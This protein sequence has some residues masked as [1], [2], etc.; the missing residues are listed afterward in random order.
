MPAITIHVPESRFDQGQKDELAEDLTQVILAIEGGADT[1]EGRSIAYVRFV[2]TPR[3]DWYVGG[4]NDG[5]YM[6]AAGMFCIE[7]NVPEGSMD[8]ARK[9]MCH[10]AITKAV[11]KATGTSGKKGAA[12]TVVIQIFEWPE[13]H[14][15]TR[16]RT[17]CL[18]YTSD[19]ADD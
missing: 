19:A 4:K 18:L 2:E 6:G 15:A 13:G 12:N 17:A 11:L 16:G 9:T 8:Q 3:E 10:K 7:L 5:T 14:L 1:P